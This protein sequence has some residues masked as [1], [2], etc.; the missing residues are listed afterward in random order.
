MSDASYGGVGS[1]NFADN[2]I[3]SG[4]TAGVGRTFLSTYPTYRMLQNGTLTSVKYYAHGSVTNG[5]KF[6]VFRPNGSNFDF[7]GESEKFTP[8]SGST[9]TRTLGTP[10]T[11][12]R[13]GDLLGYWI[14][15]DGL[16]TV[17]IGALLADSGANTVWLA[18]DNVG[19]NQN[20][21]NT[22]SDL[23]L[24]LEAFGLAPVAAM[25]GDSIEAGHGT[26][27]NEFMGGSGP[28][29]DITGELGYQ[30][31]LANASFTYQAYSRGSQTWSWVR[32]TA[33]PA[34]QSGAGV[35]QSGDINNAEYW[36]HCG[37]N[38]VFT[39]RLW[40]AV[41]ADL[42][43]IYALA[44]SR[45][46][47]ID[48][49]LPWVDSAGG[50]NANAA[51]TRTFNTNLAGWAVGKSTVRIV[52]CWAAFGVFWAGTGLNDKLNPLYDSGD[53]IH[54]NATGSA[55]LA[56]LRLTARSSYYGGGAHPVGK[57][58]QPF[59]FGAM[60][61]RRYGSF[62]GRTPTSTPPYNPSRFSAST[63]NTVFSERTAAEFGSAD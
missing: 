42:D 26:S 9:Q 48:E 52:L 6:K 43:A 27:Y 46:L 8:V 47:F 4:G 60:A 38:D 25:T 1:K 32:L 56:A 61:M 55:A 11:G 39:G 7:V 10:I 58:V 16:G 21:T 23:S 45:P 36:I 54:P 2:A 20:F 37:V 3:V 31:R 15:I 51:I 24:N 30:M 50:S 18:G 57:I 53:K 12:I 62:A 44:G 59:S 40:S 35:H 63:E 19:S 28:A 34:M 13:P 41:S 33:F 14:D 49:I 17:S 5:M 22:L 29:G